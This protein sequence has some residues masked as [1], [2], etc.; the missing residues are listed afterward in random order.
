MNRTEMLT[1]FYT[2][3][4]KELLRIIRIWPQTLV[5]PVIVMTL[6][7]VIFGKIV[8]RNMDL[9]NDVSYIRYLIP[10]LIM[11]AV[12]VN[13]FTNTV[14]SFFQAR[15]NHAVEEMTVSPMP[16]WI[17]IAG[18]VGGGMARGLLIGGLVIMTAYFFDN[19]NPI[20]LLFTITVILLTS[21]LFA[22]LG[23]INALVS[24]NYDDV[25][26][27]PTFVLTPLVYLGGVFYPIT[28]L[29]EIWQQISLLN[30]ILYIVNAFR[31]G[32]LEITSVD[33]YIALFSLFM[34]NVIAF[35]GAYRMMHLGV[36][37]RK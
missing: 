29:P 19:I 33:P 23:F 28:M 30:P 35:L 18:Y 25:T 34:F 5:P 13:S 7:F 31:Y 12:I 8:G 6:Y 22:T 36:G 27:V 20:H 15:F 11:N 24:R 10:G 17:V 37:I 9:V 1:S 26:M 2:I 14:S 32:I 16:H 4:R 21:M 3:L